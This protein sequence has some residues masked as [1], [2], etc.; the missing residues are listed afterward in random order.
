MIQNGRQRKTSSAAATVGVNYHAARIT[1]IIGILVFGMFLYTAAGNDRTTETVSS[2]FGDGAY[3]V[4]ADADTA[5]SDDR[6]TSVRE[7]SSVWS[8]LES[9]IFRLI[10]G[11]S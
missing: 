8:Y 6:V 3:Q 7:D 1:A 9:V 11:D 5:P 2:N 10:Y 4:F